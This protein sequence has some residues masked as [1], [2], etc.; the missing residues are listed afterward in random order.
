MNEYRVDI[1]NEAGKSLN[2]ERRTSVGEEQGLEEGR[3]MGRREN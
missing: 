1:G 3:K 2:W